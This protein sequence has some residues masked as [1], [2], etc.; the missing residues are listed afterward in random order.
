MY[1]ANKVDLAK[2]AHKSVLLG[3]VGCLSVYGMV[4]G[5]CR[6]GVFVLLLCIFHYMEFLSTYYYNTSQVDDDSFIM[7]D[8]DL[9]MVYIGSLV[10]YGVRKTIEYYFDIPIDIKV[11]VAIGLVLT[12][13]GQTT[14]SLA[15]Y[16]AKQSFNHYIQREQTSKHQLVTSG[17]YRYLRHPSYFGF[18][19]W[20][21]GLELW[22]GNF[23]ILLLGGYQLWNFFN[24]RIEFEEKFLV[25]FFQNDY[26]TYRQSTKTWIPLIN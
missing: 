22:L 25:D 23:V 3:F 9:H 7:E 2:V 17:I 15:M 14:R 4:N 24:K 1:D 21:I 12:V 20:F 5:Y 11:L 26:I 8:Q 6:I 13:I 10:E 16:T 18:W 19:W